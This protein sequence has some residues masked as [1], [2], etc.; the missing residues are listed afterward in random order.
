MNQSGNL[1]TTTYFSAGTQ[2]YTLNNNWQVNTKL[3]PFQFGLDIRPGFLIKPDMLIFGRVGF[4]SATLTESVYWSGV[5]NY[6]NGGAVSNLPFTVNNQI[7]NNKIAL[8]LGGGLEYYFQPGWSVRMDYTYENYGSI[9]S[10]NKINKTVMGTLPF[11]EGTLGISN[12]VNIKTISNNSVMIGI[13][14]YFA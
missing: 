1:G 5:A 2:Y 9:S 12:N 11:G 14:H 7:K 4:A 10:S 8:R 3:S 6:S 13:S